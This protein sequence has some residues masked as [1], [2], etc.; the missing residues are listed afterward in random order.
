MSYTY[1]LA[2]EEDAEQVLHVIQGAY[3]SIRELGIEFRAVHADLDMIATNIRENS[4]YILIQDSSVVATLSLK[5]LKEVTPYPF[6]YWFAVDPSYS[7]QGWGSLLLT[8]VEERIVRDT[9][10]ADGVT[11][12]TSKKHPWLLPMYERRGYERF[13]E[14]DLGKDDQLV[15]LTKKLTA[16]EAAITRLGGTYHESN[17]H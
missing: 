17:R 2:S 7:S 11:L 8:Y 10:G 5:S 9:L 3:E 15:Y 12:A 6:L 1:R 14:R 13:Y 4:C 16:A